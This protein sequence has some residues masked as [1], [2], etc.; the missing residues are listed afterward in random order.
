[1]IIYTVG[2]FDAVDED[3]NPGVLKRFAEETGGEAFLP[4][5][6][7]EV[8]PVCER[9]ARDIRSQ[10]TLTYSPANSVDD[11]KYRTVEVR[12]GGPGHK[13][14]LVR[15]RTGYFAPTAPLPEDSVGH[16]RR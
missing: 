15:T 5:A 2:L 4:D 10:Y 9:I 14:L 7:Q 16:E 1:V 11:G 13:R 3:R 6:V 12:A 8:V